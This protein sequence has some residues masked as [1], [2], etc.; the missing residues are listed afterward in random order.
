MGIMIKLFLINMIKTQ[1]N[2]Q[3]NKDYKQKMLKIITNYSLN[4]M[5]GKKNKK[6]KKTNTTTMKQHMKNVINN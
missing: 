5:N 4:K 1:N 2:T 6:N 3:Q